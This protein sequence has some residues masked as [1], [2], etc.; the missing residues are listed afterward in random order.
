MERIHSKEPAFAA[1]LCCTAKS[2]LFLFCA[3]QGYLAYMFQMRCSVIMVL[4]VK[5]AVA[6][7]RDLG[8]WARL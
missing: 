2:A 8:G 6:T 7:G 5:T 1:L 3:V 4:I